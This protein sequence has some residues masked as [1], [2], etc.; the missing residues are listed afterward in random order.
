MSATSTVHAPDVPGDDCRICAAPWPCFPAQLDY[1]AEF[2][3]RPADLA[4]HLAGWFTAT[5][6]ELSTR[7]A[8]F[9]VDALYRRHLG[10]IDLTRRP[11]PSRWR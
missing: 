6:T 8:R 9:D 7:G 11:R 10:W 4:T 1:V 2:Y 3:G 5:V